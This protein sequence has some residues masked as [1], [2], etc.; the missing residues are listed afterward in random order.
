LQS[1]ISSRVFPT[2]TLCTSAKYLDPRAGFDAIAD[3]DVQDLDV[4]FK[5]VMGTGVDL[6]AFTRSDRRRSHRGV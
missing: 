2:I 1:T 5:I 4:Q 6:K 3:A